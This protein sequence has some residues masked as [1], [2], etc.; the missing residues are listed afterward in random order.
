ML[1]AFAVGKAARVLLIDGPRRSMFRAFEQRKQVW[2]S[3]QP[4]NPSFFTLD[5]HSVPHTRYFSKNFDTARS[6]AVSSWLAESYDTRML[7]RGDDDVAFDDVKDGGACRRHKSFDLKDDVINTTSEEQQKQEEEPPQPATEHLMVDIKNVDCAFLNSEPRLARAIVELVSEADLPLLSYHCH[8]YTPVGVSCVGVMFPNYLAFHTW[9][10][11]G[12]ISFDLVASD[13][14]SILPLL[15]SIERLFGVPRSPAFPGQ[16]VPQPEIHWAHK[17]RGLRHETTTP[18]YRARWMSK[19]CVQ[20][21][22]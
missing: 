14:Q 2:S 6:A 15:S 7:E 4:N 13:S 21:L 10:E 22:P 20:D 8:K 12:V 11:S 5:G 16:S 18:L 1:I 17:L 19:R 3:H 9:P